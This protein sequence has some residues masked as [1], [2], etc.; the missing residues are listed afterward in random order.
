MLS[1]IELSMYDI[2]LEKTETT[3][4]STFYSL[5]NDYTGI[6]MIM[7]G[8]LYL[9]NVTAILYKCVL[10]IQAKLL[11]YILFLILFFDAFYKSRIHTKYY[12]SLIFIKNMPAPS[13]C[14]AP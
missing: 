1:Y 12:S 4:H 5:F 13:C 3:F 8:I 10:S 6:V 9:I 2:D 11:Y 14:A 7:S